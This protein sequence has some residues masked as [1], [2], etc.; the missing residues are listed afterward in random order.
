MHMPVA[1]RAAQQ[2]PQQQQQQQQH[3]QQLQLQPP[4]QAQTA[5]NVTSSGN[6]TGNDTGTGIVTSVATAFNIAHMRGIHDSPLN[7]LATATTTNTN[8]NANTD[9]TALTDPAL[10]TADDPTRN[11]TDVSVASKTAESQVLEA[12]TRLRSSSMG[13]SISNVPSS[14]GT[15]LSASASLNTTL[16]TNSNTIANTNTNTNTATSNI[17]TNANGYPYAGVNGLTPLS[18]IQMQMQM[19]SGIPMLPTFNMPINHINNGI[20][21]RSPL[22]IPSSPSLSHLHSLP[23]SRQGY[24]CFGFI[25][26]EFHSDDDD[27]DLDE[28][29]DDEEDDDADGVKWGC[30]EK[31]NGL[32]ELISHLRENQC[33]CRTQYITAIKSQKRDIPDNAFADENDLNLTDAM[34]SNVMRCQDMA[35][36]EVAKASNG[37]PSSTSS[38]SSSA[39]LDKKINISH[40]V[41]ATMKVE[42]K[43]TRGK[44]SRSNTKSKSKANANAKAKGT[45]KTSTNSGTNTRTRTKRSETPA[46]ASSSAA[47]AALSTKKR[48]PKKT[49]TKATKAAKAVK[50]ASPSA[51]ASASASPSSST[52]GNG[53]GAST[54]SFVCPDPLCGKT[55]SRKSNL[56]SHLVTHSTSR[57]HLC[58]TCGKAFARLSDRTRHE[59]TTHARTRTFQCRGT[60]KDGTEWG[61]GHFYS[62]ADGLRKH[63]RSNAGRHC[64]SSFLGLG[65]TVAAAEATATASAVPGDGTSTDTTAPL[66]PLA[67]TATTPTTATTATPTSTDT[68]SHQP[69]ERYVELAVENVRALG[70][71]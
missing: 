29:D 56:D 27:S 60:K 12:L 40:L 4:A 15:P 5:D 48:A 10:N 53:N 18:M 24:Y 20:Q 25:A 63:F 69:A 16:N 36:A 44:G 47:A 66:A 42:E 23:H 34:V 11:S 3:Q 35:A 8:G 32:D 51:S 19:S 70:G 71:W 14:A 39:S 52:T 17:T 57:P 1:E 38:S 6:D 65:E 21:P 62:R 26:R 37:A 59:A 58:V 30:M 43:P 49:A 2:Q 33:P 61:C 55:F 41:E 54:R 68:L 22:P 45:V 7:V 28:D 50:P 13:P 9:M 64:L 46:S 67:S 31:F